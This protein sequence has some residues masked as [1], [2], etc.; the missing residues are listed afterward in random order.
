MANE[1][2]MWHHLTISTIPSFFQ[3]YLCQKAIDAFSSVRGKEAAWKLPTLETWFKNESLK[4]R[5]RRC[6]APRTS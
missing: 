2:R 1:N 4:R 5:P 6:G 3:E